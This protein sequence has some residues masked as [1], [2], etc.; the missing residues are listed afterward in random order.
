MKIMCLGAILNA[1]TLIPLVMLQAAARPRLV[2][3]NHLVEVPLYLA[4]LWVAS[5]KYGLFGAAAASVARSVIDYVLMTW[6]SVHVPALA[7]RRFA[8]FPTPQLIGAVL[9]LLAVSFLGRAL[10]WKLLV[11]VVLLVWCSWRILP[12]ARR[13]L[14]LRRS[15]PKG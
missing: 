9:A 11:L 12:W 5:A 1:Q 14:G 10:I 8:E 3:L 13:E 15:L 4:I 6:Q 7:A 2:A